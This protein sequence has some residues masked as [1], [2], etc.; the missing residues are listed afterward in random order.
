MELTVKTRYGLKVLLDIAWYGRFGTVQRRNILARQ[1]V[2]GEHLD[3]V[4]S[5]LRRCGLIRSFRG[6]EG[7]YFLAREPGEI[8]LWDVVNSV[9]EE[10]PTNTSNQED[11][12]HEMLRYVVE[13]ALD[14]LAGV[15][16][17]SLK[18]VTLGMLL[19]E[20]EDRMLEDGV[21]PLQFIAV[22]PGLE[23]RVGAAVASV[24]AG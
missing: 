21:D 9:E 4:L 19:E 13:P 15:V 10:K 6:R 14:D 22:K 2:P 16:R 11:W 20:A 5:R 8:S 24:A 12:A 17:R 7:G 3:V 1:G 23:T 18:R